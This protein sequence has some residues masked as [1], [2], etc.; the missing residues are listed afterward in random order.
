MTVRTID[1][2]ILV[3]VG[4]E[5]II[6]FFDLNRSALIEFDLKRLEDE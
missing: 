6:S 4:E 3:D 5:A 2:N 1:G